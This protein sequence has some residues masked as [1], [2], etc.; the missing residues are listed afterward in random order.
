MIIEK[1]QRSKYIS[2]SEF[3]NLIGT[4]L[5]ADLFEVSADTV[6]SYKYGYRQPSLKV[7]KRI[8]RIT[9]GRLNF[10][11]IYGPIEEDFSAR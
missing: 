8:M 5:A 11:S 10:E 3:I 2:L 9:N 1:K 7:A 6:K 4:D